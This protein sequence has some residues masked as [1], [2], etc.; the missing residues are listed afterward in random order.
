MA[1]KLVLVFRD[2]GCLWTLDPRGLWVSLNSGSVSLD[3]G[4]S[5]LWVS[6]HSGLVF[7]VAGEGQVKA[8]GSC[9]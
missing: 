8:R 9:S 5:G 1:G 7:V 4:P 3:S 2:F 6:L